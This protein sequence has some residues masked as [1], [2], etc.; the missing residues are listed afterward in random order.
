MCVCKQHVVGEEGRVRPVNS[1][2]HAVL[3]DFFFSHQSVV[4]IPRESKRVVANIPADRTCLRGSCSDNNDD[5]DI[6]ISVFSRKRA[7]WMAL[8]K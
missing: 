1:L 7:E 6:T 5:S 2:S 8:K 4:E 3:Y